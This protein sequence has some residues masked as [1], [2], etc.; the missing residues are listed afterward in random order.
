[1][2]SCV[3]RITV[4][5]IVV[6]LAVA[7]VPDR[8]HRAS[9]LSQHSNPCRVRGLYVPETQPHSDG[10]ISLRSLRFTSSGAPATSCNFMQG[11]PFFRRGAN[12]SFAPGLRASVLFRRFSRVLCDFKL[13][14]PVEA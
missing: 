7:T 13:N 2:L 6:N 8:S 14:F 12:G 5:M 10:L 9:F 1:M 11:A 3:H 4:I